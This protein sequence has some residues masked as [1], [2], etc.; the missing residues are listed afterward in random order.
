[1]V[2]WKTNILSGLKSRYKCVGY[3]MNRRQF[4][5]QVAATCAGITGTST[6]APAVVWGEEEKSIPLK[7]NAMQQKWTWNSIGMGPPIEVDA[8]FLR[9]YRVTIRN[10]TFVPPI[11]NE[12]QKPKTR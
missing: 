1:M 3:A 9:K 7:L 10:T 4:F 8:E 2:I 11:K 6:V 5:K 12:N